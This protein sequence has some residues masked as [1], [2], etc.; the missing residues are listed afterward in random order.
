MGFKE[1]SP[2]DL[3]LRA[4]HALDPG[5]IIEIREKLEFQLQTAEHMYRTHMETG[6]N[7]KEILADLNQGIEA[8]TYTIAFLT[9][10]LEE[11][12]LFNHQ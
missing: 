3:M 12:N 6:A 10:R 11:Y 2:A 1:E 8:M 9:G 4:E 5:E 7:N